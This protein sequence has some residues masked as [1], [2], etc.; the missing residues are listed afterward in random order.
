DKHLLPLKTSVLKTIAVIG[1]N[2]TRMN[3][4]GGFGAGVKA[5]YEI[6]PLEGLQNAFGKNV[7]IKF[8]QGYHAALNDKHVDVNKPD[9]ILIQDAV[10]A[11]KNSDVAILFIGGNRDYESEGRDRKDLSLP[12]GEQALV[13][14]IAFI[15]IF[16]N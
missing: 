15:F 3:H 13:E 4:L 14:I 6:T 12:F 10:N 1:D 9:S 11:A 8:A 7:N 16:L 2:A 5:K